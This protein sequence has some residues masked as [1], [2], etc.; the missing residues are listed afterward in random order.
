MSGV[1][2]DGPPRINPAC[3]DAVR[4]LHSY[5]KTSFVNVGYKLNGKAI[6]PTHVAWQSIRFVLGVI[7]KVCLDVI[8]H[9]ASNAHRTPDSGIKITHSE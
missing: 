1:A 6:N 8:D 5:E 7:D 3:F 2:L 4:Q 9:F